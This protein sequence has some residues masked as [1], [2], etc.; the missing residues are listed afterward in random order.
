MSF[1]FY[2][3]LFRI[4]LGMYILNLISQ[5]PKANHNIK[6]VYYEAFRNIVTF[7]GIGYVTKSA[8]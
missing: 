6:Q 8:S 3:L 1:A 4:K 7:S 5:Q 2:I